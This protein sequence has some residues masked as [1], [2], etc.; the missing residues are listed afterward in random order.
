MVTYLLAHALVLGHDESEQLQGSNVLLW[1]L[2]GQLH[3]LDNAPSFSTARVSA[4][5]LGSA[6]LSNEVFFGA[7]F[8]ALGGLQ[9]LLSVCL[10]KGGVAIQKALMVGAMVLGVIFMYAM[11]NVYMINTVPTGTTSTHR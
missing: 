11:I 1:A 7:A 9:W 10:R 5:L 2:M 4:A 6:W 8:F 3:V